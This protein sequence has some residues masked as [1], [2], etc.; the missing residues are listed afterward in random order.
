MRWRHGWCDTSSWRHELCLVGRAGY[1]RLC[2]SDMGLRLLSCGGQA[3]GASFGVGCQEGD[4]LFGLAA[5]F[6]CFSSRA[7]HWPFFTCALPWFSPFLCASFLP[8]STHVCTGYIPPP[9]CA[10]P[11]ARAWASATDVAL[12]WRSL[13]PFGTSPGQGSA[14]ESRGSVGRRKAESTCASMREAAGIGRARPRCPG[15][16]VSL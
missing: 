8:E 7:T 15:H 10:L 11:E 4:Q 5:S 13:R 12:A 14:G 9:T 1:S 16:V 2:T 6:P 3:T